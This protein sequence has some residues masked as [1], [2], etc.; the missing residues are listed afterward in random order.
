MPT[1]VIRG[2]IAGT[3]AREFKR[4]AILIEARPFARLNKPEARAFA[5]VAKRYGD[6][7]GMPVLLR[8]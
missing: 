5:T 2:R 1:I 3:W 4:A 6:F 7:M 8:Q